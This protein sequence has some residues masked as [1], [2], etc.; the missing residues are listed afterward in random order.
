M[1]HLHTSGSC[2]EHSLTHATMLSHQYLPID[3]VASLL[4]SCPRSRLLE[5]AGL[6]T[7]S[8]KSRRYPAAPW[9]SVPTSNCT[10][11]K[12]IKSEYLGKQ[13]SSSR[14]CYLQLRRDY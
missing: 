11:L 2:C 9:G 8:S 14:H 1:L 5:D 13:G 3:N 12:T 7:I 10:G 4:Q 6:K